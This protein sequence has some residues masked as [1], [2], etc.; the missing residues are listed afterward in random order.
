MICGVGIGGLVLALVLVFLR[1]LVFDEREG[2]EKG[3]WGVAFG[4]ELVLF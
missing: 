1:G 4:L 3:E 2:V